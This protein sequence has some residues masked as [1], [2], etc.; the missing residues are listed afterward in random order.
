MLRDERMSY[1][2]YSSARLGAGYEQ[3][4][5]ALFGPGRRCAGA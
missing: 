5:H 2:D 3:L 1:G 4:N